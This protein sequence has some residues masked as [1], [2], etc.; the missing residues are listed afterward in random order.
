MRI[1]PTLAAVTQPGVP[2]QACPIRVPPRVT[3]AYE[4][5]GYTQGLKSYLVEVSTQVELNLGK[6]RRIRVK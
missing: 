1:V 5:L 4:A 2:T 6:G 3:P